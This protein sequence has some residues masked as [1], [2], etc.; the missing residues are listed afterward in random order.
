MP[1]RF[2]WDPFT[3]IME[4]VSEAMPPPPT[5]PQFTA[6][7]A[8]AEAKTKAFLDGV[9]EKERRY[10]EAYEK[11]HE[12]IRDATTLEARQKY[13]FHFDRGH[14][15]T[16]QYRDEEV[17]NRD[18][19]I[20]NVWSTFAEKW[21]GSTCKLTTAAEK[22]SGKTYRT[23]EIDSPYLGKRVIGPTK[24]PEARHLIDES[25]GG[26]RAMARQPQVFLPQR[27]GGG[28]PSGFG[29]LPSASRADLDHSLSSA[30]YDRIRSAQS[31]HGHDPRGFNYHNHH[32]HHQHSAD[33]ALGP[34]GFDHHQHSA[35][36]GGPRGYDYYQQS[37]H[38]PYSPFSRW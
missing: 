2:K 38:Y 5:P 25:K 3:G 35:E 21:P 1:Q 22:P 11:M 16:V 26:F 12:L 13:E 30:E 36:W 37:G 19:A 14:N 9:H 34:H 10:L 4:S 18:T 28:A 6:D 23:V 32:H 8:E 17:K 33:W 29:H 15:N 24:V 7:Y 31:G 27:Y 20:K